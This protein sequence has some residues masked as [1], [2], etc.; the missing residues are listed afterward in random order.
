MMLLQLDTHKATIETRL[1][2]LEVDLALAEEQV[3]MARYFKPNEAKNH[4]M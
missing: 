1:E 3:D 2:E 4:C